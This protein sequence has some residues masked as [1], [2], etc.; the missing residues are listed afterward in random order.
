MKDIFVL[1]TNTT[2][3]QSVG[4]TRLTISLELKISHNG[5]WW[6]LFEDSQCQSLLQPR[7]GATLGVLL[8]GISMHL[9]RDEAITPYPIHLILTD[10]TNILVMNWWVL[11]RGKRSKREKEMEREG[12]IG[13]G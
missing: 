3:L 5:L 7:L 12:E 6:Q 11:G 10:E 2:V 9:V 13:N 4:T 8:W 1:N